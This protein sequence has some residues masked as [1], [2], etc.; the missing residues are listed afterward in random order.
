MM[1]KDLQGGPLT[2]SKTFR[3]GSFSFLFIQVEEFW[4]RP[5]NQGQDFWKRSLLKYFNLE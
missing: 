3:G 1:R 2:R 5:L 4:T